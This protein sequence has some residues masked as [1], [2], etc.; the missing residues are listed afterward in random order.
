MSLLGHV[1][2]MKRKVV[3]PL[4]VIQT[5]IGTSRPPTR[6]NPCPFPSSPAFPFPV[7]PPHP[8]CQAPPNPAIGVW[9]SAVSSLRVV[10]GG[11]PAAK[12]VLV[13]FEARKPFC[14]IN[15]CS[16]CTDKMS[17]EIEKNVFRPNSNSA[18]LLEGV[19]IATV[20]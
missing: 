5:V 9:G 16:F 17:V 13:Y 20:L 19:V 7:S 3:V 15:F 2:V 14:G 8:R 12:A 18:K 4:N 6:A 10:R 1:G 11:A